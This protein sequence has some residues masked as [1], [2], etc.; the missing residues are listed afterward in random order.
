MFLGSIA[1]LFAGILFFAGS[2]PSLAMAQQQQQTT[3]TTIGETG[4]TATTTSASTTDQSATITGASTSPL[5]FTLRIGEEGAGT[6]GGGDGTTTA[7]TPGTTTTPPPTSGTTT[8][9]SSPMQGGGSSDSA[10]PTTTTSSATSTN[11]STRNIGIEVNLVRGN[12]APIILPINVTIPGNV[13]NLELC[14]SATVVSSADEMCQPVLRTID[15]TQNG[16]AGATETTTSGTTSSSPPS[17]SPSSPLSSSSAPTTAAPTTSS[18]FPPATTGG[19]SLIGGIEET[20][21]ITVVAPITVQIQNAQLCAQLL[22]SGAQSCNQI[23]LNP[24][25]TSYTPVNVDMTASPTPTIISSSE[26]AGTTTST[27]AASSTTTTGTTDTGGGATSSSSTTTTTPTSPSTTTTTTPPTSTNNNTT[28][29]TG[30][31]TSSSAPPQQ[32]APSSSGVGGIT[33]SDLHIDFLT[34]SGP[35]ASDTNTYNGA[36]PV[37]A[38]IS[39]TITDNVGNRDVTYRLI[40]NDGVL[41]EGVRHFD[42][43]GSERVSFGIQ[44]LGGFNNV[45]S[46]QGWFAIEI[47]Q[48]VQLQSNRVE[49][50]TICTPSTGGAPPSGSSSSGG[51]TAS[52]SANPATYNGACPVTIEFSGTITDNVGNR[53]VTYRT[54]WSDGGTTGEQV[55]HFDQPGSQSISNPASGGLPYS[56]TLGG[57][58]LMSYQGWMAIEILQPVQLQSNRAEF[59]FT[60]TPSTGGGSPPPAGGTDTI[61]PSLSVPVDRLNPTTYGQSLSYEVS[62]TDN[63]DGTARLGANN[64]LTQEDNVGGSVTI[65]CIPGPGTILPIGDTTVECIATDA[66]GNR[67]TASFIVAVVPTTTTPPNAPSSG[68]IT[69]YLSASPATHQGPCPVGIR[70][71]GTITDSVGNRDVTYRFIFSSG[72]ITPEEVIHF[73]QPGTTGVETGLN[74]GES[75]GWVAIEILQPVQLQ[76]N[77]AEYTITCTAPNM[78][79][80]AA[81]ETITIEEP[82]DNEEDTT[83]P[84]T[85]DEEGAGDDGGDDGTDSGTPPPATTDEGGGEGET[86][87]PPATTDEGGG[88]GETEPPP[89]TT[90]EGGGEGG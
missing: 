4:T 40:M 8:P 25:Q 55:I 43:P 66:A 28:N 26:G 11:L 1:F 61:A 45:Q 76:S 39:G 19:N 69:A 37:G 67:G 73:N 38:S 42:Q 36:C 79:A 64:M 80:L 23:I 17:S 12:E 63:V 65:S 48:P 41:P 24:Q 60:C 74:S 2:L 84:I 56:W 88:E 6:G 9:F 34:A 33:I 35:V 30:G 7:T 10:G 29:T 90:D 44:T 58:T 13:N 89:A 62:A 83:A 57:D 3:T 71:T 75:Q 46:Y 87:P 47:L 68:G 86:E 16:G 81:N 77:R 18:S 49:F 72:T 85:T 53:D 14:A 70:F 31:A 52:V 50:Q 78:G 27:G 5:T 22:S 32:G 82:A 21:V 59:E 51:I 20:A 15:L 54:I